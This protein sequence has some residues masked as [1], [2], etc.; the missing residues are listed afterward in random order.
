VT[1]NDFIEWLRKELYEMLYNR[2]IDHDVLMVY[3]RLIH[4]WRVRNEDSN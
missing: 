1:D 3:I 2:E 4:K